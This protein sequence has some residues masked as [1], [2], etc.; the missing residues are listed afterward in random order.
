MFVRFIG[1]KWPSKS[2]CLQKTKTENNVEKKKEVLNF[3]RLKC[4]FYCYRGKSN[5]T[6]NK[7]KKKELATCPPSLVLAL[8]VP[9]SS[10]QAMRTSVDSYAWF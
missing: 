6:N 10:N 8:T 3:G 7:D 9:C 5:E 1:K 4:E 2:E